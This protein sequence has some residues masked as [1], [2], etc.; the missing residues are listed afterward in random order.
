MNQTKNT[1]AV[2]DAHALK[3]N[4]E[5][6]RERPKSAPPKKFVILGLTLLLGVKSSNHFCRTHGEKDTTCVDIL[7]E[8]FLE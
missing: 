3:E 4:G 2:S 6:S 7:A 8:N 5:T 1:D